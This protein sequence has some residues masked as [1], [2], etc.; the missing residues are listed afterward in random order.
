MLPTQ[1]CGDRQQPGGKFAFEV[2]P[3][4]ML[5]HSNEG[6][7]GKFDRVSVVANISQDKGMQRRLP[8]LH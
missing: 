1:I 4:A 2:K 6:F 7:C 3:A 8:P 5:I